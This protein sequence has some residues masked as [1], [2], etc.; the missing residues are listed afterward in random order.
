MTLRE[1]RL[2]L[3]GSSP[4][5]QTLRQ[6]IHRVAPLDSTV[7]VTGETG[8]GKERVARLIHALSGRAGGPFV[9]I[10]C[11]A[12]AETMVEAEL[13][14]HE[15]GAFT[16]AIGRRVGRLESA[17]GGTLFIDEVGDMPLPVQ[18]KLLRVL[19]ERELERVGGS[20]AVSLDVRVVAATH[21][22]LRSAVR[23]GTFRDDL[24]FRLNVVPVVVPALRERGDDAVQLALHFLDQV[25]RRNRLHGLLLGLEAR[26]A[27]VHH[28]WPG[29]VRELQN[30]VERAAASLGGPGVITP[31]LLGIGATFARPENGPGGAA[32]S[33]EAAQPPV[34]GA[35]L[36]ERLSA[37]ERQIVLETLKRHGGIQTRAAAELGLT[38]QAL[39]KKLARWGLQSAEREG[40]HGDAPFSRAG[41]PP[42]GPHRMAPP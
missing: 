37:V 15:K 42:R 34:A 25:Q 28:R 1:E 40:S 17:Q 26:Q 32:A 31:A 29:N 16:G 12:F 22:D 19:Q 5:M 9:A 20:V 3:L 38:R 8:T 2:D 13:F 33:P 36:R 11:A 35:T 4:P 23:A 27:V 30:A 14:G 7:L 21:R 39:A 18:A 6:L 41:R 10:N 24:Y